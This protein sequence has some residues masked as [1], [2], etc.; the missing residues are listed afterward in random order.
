M[1][2]F[3]FITE[4]AE[5]QSTQLSTPEGRWYNATGKSIA[6]I[7]AT[8]QNDFVYQPGGAAPHDNV[9]TSWPALVAAVNAVF[10]QRRILID[11]LNTGDVGPTVP[12]GNWSLDNVLLLGKFPSSGFIP[13]LTFLDGAHVTSRELG[14]QDVN[15]ASTSTTSVITVDTDGLDVTLLDMFVTSATAPFFHVASGAQSTNFSLFGLASFGD[16]TN[17]V[18]QVDNG[19][20]TF[21]NLYDTATLFS[22]ATSGAG[23]IELSFFPV[24]S[25][26]SGASGPIGDA[27]VQFPQMAGLIPIIQDPQVPV[28]PNMLF[29]ANLIVPIQVLGMGAVQT[30]NANTADVPG[31]N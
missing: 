30:A 1:G 20:T 23:A 8:G 29:L 7:A 19:L 9:Y 10:G 27:A 24:S 17:P 25:Q 3:P 4:L 12:A 15:L 2:S 18:L 28:T 11:S 5:G 6:S 14:V 16:G 21:V 13:T 31:T 26:L 22:G